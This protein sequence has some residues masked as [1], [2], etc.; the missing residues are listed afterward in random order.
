MVE[1]K[2]DAEG[3]PLSIPMETIDNGEAIQISRLEEV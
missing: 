1:W 2:Q 3:N